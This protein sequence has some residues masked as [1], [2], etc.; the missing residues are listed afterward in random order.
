VSATP[1]ISA[2]ARRARR[3]FLLA[4]A[5]IATGVAVAALPAAL[6]PA[7]KDLP[8]WTLDDGPKVVAGDGLFELI[9]GGADLF[10]EY[11]FK[12]VTAS[13]W[14]NDKGGTLQVEVY[15]MA[16]DA[17]AYGI[18]SAMKSAGGPGAGVGQDSQLNDYYL[19][20]WQGSF[21]VGLTSSTP[22]PELPRLLRGAAQ[23]LAARLDG[24]GRV[25]ALV[26]ALP[27]KDRTQVH[28]FRGRIALSNIQALDAGLIP[29]FTE[30]VCSSGPA[31]RTFVLQL[32]SAERAE[33]ALAGV[34]KTVGANGRYRAVQSGREAC[35]FTDAAARGFSYVREGALLRLT[36]VEGKGSPVGTGGP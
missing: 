34:A 4:A 15:H 28:Y 36:I 17:A 18:F 35:A 6:L 27:A 9:D 3:S 26:G 33:A 8:G 25:P 1:G 30:G 22:S 29:A 7:A 5:V 32:A 14:I 21:F 19:L 24:P 16:D 12:E 11:G 31:G 23:A 20:F 2:W 10:L 13:H